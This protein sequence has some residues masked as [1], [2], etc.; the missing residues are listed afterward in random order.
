MQLNTESQLLARLAF[1][2]ESDDAPRPV[3]FLTGAGLS[4]GAVPS[5]TDII[6]S[7][8]GALSSHEQAEFDADLAS[9]SDAGGKYRRAFKYLA[10][11]RPP[12]VRNRIV[13]VATLRACDLTGVEE[14]QLVARS[15]ELES[16]ISR[17]KLPAGQAALGRI[18]AGVEP[19]LRGP[20]LTTNF[21]PL[22]EIAVRRA[23]GPAVQFSYSDNSSFLQNSRIQ[24]AACVIHLHGYWRESETLSLPDQLASQRPSLEGSIKVLLERNTLVVIGYGGWSDVVTRSLLSVVEEQRV[25]DLDV[26][27]CMHEPAEA[28]AAAISTNENLSRLAAATSNVQFYAGIDANVFLPALEKRLASSLS[29]PDSASSR[30]VAPLDWTVVDDRFVESARSRATVESALTFFDGRQPAWYDACSNHVPMRADAVAIANDVSTAIQKGESSLTLVIGPSAEG[31]T[32]LVMQACR[33]IAAREDIEPTVLALSENQG[34]PSDLLA[35]LPVSRPYV[36]FVDDAYLHA[37]RIQDLVSRIQK[38]GRHDVHVIAAS[39]DTDWQSSGSANIA[40]NQFIRTKQYLVHGLSHVDASS[41]VSAW[42][43]I[44]AVALGELE[45]LE[46]TERVQ[47]LMDASFGIGVKGR[48]SLLGAMLATRYGPGL[49][50]HIR[51]LLR[52]IQ[53]R[54]VHSGKSDF[55]LL[56][57][58]LMI[59]VPHSAD[60]Q[61]LTPRT[62]A[63]A[64]DLSVAELR[65]YV[66]VPL[67]DEAAITYSSDRIVTRHEYIADEIVDLALEDELE[68][69]SAVRRLVT[70]AVHDAAREGRNSGAAKIARLASRIDVP[71]VSIAAAQAAVEAAPADLSYRITQGKALRDAEQYIQAAEA[72]GAALSLVSDP[73]NSPL[74]R[75]FFYEWAVLEGVTRRPSRNAVVAAIALQDSAVFPPA[76]RSLTELAFG[77]LLL[78]LKRMYERGRNRDVLYG[79]AAVAQICREIGTETPRIWIRE[80][81][82]HVEHAPKYYP[83]FVVNYPRL[84]EIDLI[85][86][87]LRAAVRIARTTLEDPLPYRMPRSDGH[88]KA[89]VRQLTGDGNWWRS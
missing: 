45:V 86:D 39:R 69:E 38:S 37:P 68:I 13:Q 7:V 53:P 77:S 11:A 61:D 9:V 58:L 25:E 66:L 30:L 80:A 10:G 55:S 18:L 60:L 88:F 21:D 72:N 84:D 71:R 24:D 67:G 50:E 16:Q 22:T 62:L 33:L 42:T 2:F 29:Y 36:C 70:A 27:W 52:R 63:N 6:H 65:A 3:A 4:L 46:P 26:L 73:E 40:W 19:A 31:K 51:Q 64:L 57:A 28:A 8:R 74:V 81:E 85:D 79:L 54:L 82:R 76:S 43:S 23:G 49:R 5:V 17:W 48:G 32:T 75:G 44:G 20:V 15:G 47:H 1:T 87:S 35:Q 78:A 89:T 59:A 83:D 12:R 34:F 14:D 41:M 56:D